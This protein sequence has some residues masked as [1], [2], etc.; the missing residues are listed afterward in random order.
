MNQPERLEGN[1]PSTPQP[2]FCSIAPLGSGMQA[3][4]G[5][6]NIRFKVIATL[7]PLTRLDFANFC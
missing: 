4:R 1:L 2:V 7:L 3:A 6:G 5:D